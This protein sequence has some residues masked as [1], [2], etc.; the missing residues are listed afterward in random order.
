MEGKIYWTDFDWVIGG[1]KKNIKNSPVS[2]PLVNP[3]GDSTFHVHRHRDSGPL[4]MQPPAPPA[5]GTWRSSWSNNHVNLVICHYKF[6]LKTMKSRSFF[7]FFFIF[8]LKIILKI[9]LESKSFIDYCNLT[10]RLFSNYY[11]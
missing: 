8:L 4:W 10:R 1:G 7:F 5:A 11:R 9:Y 6:F 2:C 3:F